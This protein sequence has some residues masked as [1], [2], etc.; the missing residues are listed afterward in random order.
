MF[1]AI[2]E[3]F[4]NRNAFV[5]SVWRRKTSNKA[6]FNGAVKQKA[7]DGYM[8]AFFS[9]GSWV[10]GVVSVHL[11]VCVCV[12]SHSAWDNWSSPALHK[13]RLEEHEHAYM[14]ASL[15]RWVGRRLVRAARG[16]RLVPVHHSSHLISGSE[17]F[18]PWWEDLRRQS[19]VKNTD[20]NTTIYRFMICRC[21][22]L[23]SDCSLI[24][25]LALSADV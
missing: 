10:V 23:Y 13:P 21:S 9:R 8:E 14:T 1:C 19:R 12:Y 7:C 5:I 20:I 4:V 24:Y 25:R 15:T 3:S 22:S 11:S 16:S 2:R 18:S 17:I 6:S